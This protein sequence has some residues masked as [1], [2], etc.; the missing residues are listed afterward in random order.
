MHRRISEPPRTRYIDSA[1]CI[2]IKKTN[3]C[4]V[5]LVETLVYYVSTQQC[6]STPRSSGFEVPPQKN[7]TFK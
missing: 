3:R 2:D 4:L 6:Y 5:L 7:L 1:G